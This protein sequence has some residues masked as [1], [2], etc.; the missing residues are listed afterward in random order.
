MSAYIIRRLAALVINLFLISMFLFVALTVL[1]PGD[2]ALTILTETADQEQRD[3]FNR[4][5]GLDKSVPEQYVRWASRVVTGNFGISFVSGLSVTDEF[6][7]RLPVTMEIMFLSFTFTSIVGTVGGVISAV[8]QDTA[9]DYAVRFFAV[10]A[11]SIPGFLLLTLL[12]IVPARWFEYAPPFGATEY[13]PWRL[14]SLGELKDNLQLM[15]PPT[16]I[17]SISTSA[18]L[19]RLTRTAMLDVLRQDYL[20]T[21]RSKGLSERRV[22]VQHGVRNAATTVLTFMG[23]QIG[24]LLGGSVILEN[25]MALPGLGQW[26]LQA[27]QFEDV[28]IFLLFALY[29]S[30]MLMLV[31]LLVDLLYAVMDPRIK[32]S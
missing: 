7:S 11:V 14:E 16:L 27:L 8:K 6:F 18:I 32:Y 3:A 9:W 24:F 21:A 4:L 22:I 26:G 15:I 20:R 30:G 25:I 29:A 5:H 1:V 12:L 31:N 28:P 10:F 19:M 23:L 2:P 13:L 17:L